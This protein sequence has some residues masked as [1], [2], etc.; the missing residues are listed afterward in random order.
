MMPNTNTRQ[1]AVPRNRPGHSLRFDAAA[2]SAK[3]EQMLEPMLGL[4]S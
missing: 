1:S 4:Q 2:R 3:S